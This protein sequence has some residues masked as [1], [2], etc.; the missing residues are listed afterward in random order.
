[1]PQGSILGL[2]L[3]LLYINDIANSSEILK[4]ILYA[5]DTNI[6]I[7]VRI[8]KNYVKLLIENYLLL[9]NGSNQTVSQSI[10][11]NFFL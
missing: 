8:F 9:Y 4:F 1:M 5:D 11:R 2:L 3:F 7:V 10:Q 6:F